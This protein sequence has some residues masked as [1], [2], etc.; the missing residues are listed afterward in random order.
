[1]EIVTGA[2]P[3]ELRNDD[4]LAGMHLAKPVVELD[5]VVDRA[6]SIEAFPIGQD[7]RGD[8]VDRRGE[9][10]M[11]DPNRPDFTCSYRDRARSLHLLDELDQPRHGHFGAQRRFVA[12]HDGVDIAVVPGEI[13]R[14]ANFPLVAGLVLVDPGADGDLEAEFRGDRRDEFSAAGCRIGA[15]GAGVRR[16]GA[17]IGPD[18]FSGRTSAAVRMR[19]IGEWRIGN[20]GKL[21]GN[22]GGRPHRFQQNPNAGM[23]ARN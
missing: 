11:I 23:H 20:A 3:T 21:P 9:L 14:R 19:G 17:Q 4:P 22:V 6:R 18:L 2:R 10:R 16:Y 15:D 12:D 5:R 1:M 13:E 8:E 7:M